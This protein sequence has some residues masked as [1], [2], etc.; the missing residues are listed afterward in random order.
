MDVVNV[1][2]FNPK[3]IL[4]K[5]EDKV[6]AEIK[7]VPAMVNIILFQNNELFTGIIALGSLSASEMGGA[8][9]ALYSRFS[10]QIHEI[11]ALCIGKDADFVATEFGFYDVMMAITA[12]IQAIVEETKFHSESKKKAAKTIN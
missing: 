3:P 9:A 7:K 5:K 12:I 6:I 1:D 2:I 8:L 4:F 10:E 11:I